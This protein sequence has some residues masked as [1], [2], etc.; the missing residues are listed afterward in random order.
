MTDARE[1]EMLTNPYKVYYN[2][3]IEGAIGKTDLY[4]ERFIKLKDYLGWL[5]T[6][7]TQ[8]FSQYWDYLSIY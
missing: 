2:H 6:L 7:I 8:I 4:T 5:A 1:V 3:V